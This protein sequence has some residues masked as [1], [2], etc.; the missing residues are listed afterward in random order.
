MKLSIVQSDIKWGDVAK[1]IEACNELI[2]NHIEN[3]DL[4]VFPEMFL[5]GYNIRPYHVKPGDIKKQYDW[6]ESFSKE[7]EI[8]LAGSILYAEGDSFYNQFIISH[9]GKTLGTYNKKHLFTPGGEQLAYAKGNSREDIECNSWK[10]RPSICFD[11]RFPVWL[12]NDSDY[13]LMIC[14]AN[15]PARRQKAWDILLKARAVENQCYVVGVNR[16]GDDPSGI[17]YIGG[18]QVIDPLGNVLVMADDKEQVLECQLEK[19]DITLFRKKFPIL[20]E[21]DE[22]ILK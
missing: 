5:T 19:E 9:S 10:I 8:A 20:P 15:W 6:V 14:V 16:V 1:N 4:L 22:F 18:S 21:R 13:D 7:H 3:A 11:L 12:R 2:A 17:N